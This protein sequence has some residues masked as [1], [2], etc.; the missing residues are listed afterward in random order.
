MILPHEYNNFT[1][2][3]TKLIKYDNIASYYY[4]NFNLILNMDD[5]VD[6]IIDK[7]I[8]YI[9]D[10]HT[11][12]FGHYFYES[13]IFYKNIIELNK[14][15]SNV[16]LLT[17]NH[18]KYVNTLFKLFNINNEIVYELKHNNICFFPVLFSLNNHNINQEY[19][20]KLINNI[21]YDINHIIPLI[22]ENNIIL[23]PRNKIDNYKPNDRLIEY[24]D[25]IEHKIINIGGMVIDTYQMNNLFYQFTLIKNS[26]IIILDYGSSFLVN[27]I[28]LKNKKIIV[29]DNSNGLN[30]Q[31]SQFISINII[32]NI[33]MKNN[34]VII[35]TSHNILHNLEHLL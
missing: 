8:Y 11:D 33:I 17:S 13:F 9:I 16:K 31:S 21:I 26:N 7:H 1:L 3:E 5:N 27:C 18:K 20:K 32:T 19:F 12:A 6:D 4:D 23:L 2:N 22:N 35:T 25:E 34:T 29:I 15:Y 14:L 24:I 10:T 28:F 30:N